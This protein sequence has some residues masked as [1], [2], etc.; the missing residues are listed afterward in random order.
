MP[1]KGKTLTLLLREAEGGKDGY[2]VPAREIARLLGEGQNTRTS[3]LKQTMFLDGRVAKCEA[4]HGIRKHPKSGALIGSAP[5][6]IQT[7]GTEAFEAECARLELK[8]GAGFGSSTE[9]KLAALR[10]KQKEG[11]TMV[12]TA[13]PTVYLSYARMLKVQLEHMADQ[14]VREKKNADAHARSV[15]QSSVR[16]AQARAENAESKTKIATL[17][18]RL[19]ALKVDIGNERK[20]CASLCEEKAAASLARAS[21]KALDAQTQTVACVHES[22]ELKDLKKSYKTLESENRALK[23][24]EEQMQAFFA[25]MAPPKAVDVPKRAREAPSP[26]KPPAKRNTSGGQREM[27]PSGSINSRL[28]TI[29]S[30]SSESKSGAG[31]DEGASS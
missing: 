11:I 13:V 9:S 5:P 24:R 6:V 14:L 2:A 30:S 29:D 26:A 21:Q 15:T 8:T 31:S 12:Q 22:D 19:D 4:K 16:E 25:S 18:A 3:L 20:E 1:E 17:S 10:E 23:L 7:V 27:D 28:D